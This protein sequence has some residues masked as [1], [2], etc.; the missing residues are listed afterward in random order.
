M[1]N[2]A[3]LAQE[4]RSHRTGLENALRTRKAHPT[5]GITKADLRERLARLEGLLHAYNI[6]VNGWASAA[7]RMTAMDT[8]KTEFEFD[9]ALLVRSVAD[10]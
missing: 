2:A 3:L 5:Y 4:I 1:T 6:I 8:A 7:V 9:L 10:A